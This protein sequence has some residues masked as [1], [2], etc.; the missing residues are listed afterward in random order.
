MH[1][2]TP[3]ESLLKKEL[4]KILALQQPK[5]PK[6]AK[7]ILWVD[8]TD[9]E[10]ISGEWEKDQYL[11]NRTNF[12]AIYALIPDIHQKNLNWAFIYQILC[13]LVIFHKRMK[14][15]FYYLVLPSE[16]EPEHTNSPKQIFAFIKH[17]IEPS[18]HVFGIYRFKA[19]FY[20]NSPGNME[21]TFYKNIALDSLNQVK[22]KF[23]GETCNL[24]LS[25][26]P[27]VC[28]DFNKAFKESLDQRAISFSG[29]LPLTSNVTTR[30]DFISTFGY[31]NDS[32]LEI[33][34]EIIENALDIS[35]SSCQPLFTSPDTPL[36][37]IYN[38]IDAFHNFLPKYFPHRIEF[39]CNL[40]LPTPEQELPTGL[41]CSISSG[42]IN[43]DSLHNEENRLTSLNRI[44]QIFESIG[45]Q[46]GLL[47]SQLNRR[48]N[49]QNSTRI[50]IDRGAVK[51]RVKLESEE[52]LQ[53]ITSL[54]D[55]EY[56]L[57]SDDQYILFREPELF[58][59]SYINFKEFLFNRFLFP[60]TM[61][62]WRTR[63][64]IFVIPIW[65]PSPIFKRT[66][67]LPI[68]C[69]LMIQG[70]RL[71]NLYR[72]IYFSLA[73]FREQFKE[74]G[75][76]VFEIKKRR[77]C[78]DEQFKN[79][80]EEL[81]FIP[82][83]QDRICNYDSLN[84]LYFIENPLPEKA[85]LIEE[86]LRKSE[87]VK[88]I[89]QWILNVFSLVKASFNTPQP[90]ANN[91]FEKYWVPAYYNYH[92]AWKV[93][94][95]MLCSLKDSRLFHFDEVILSIPEG[96]CVYK[97]CEYIDNPNVEDEWFQ[98]KKRALEDCSVPFR[99]DVIQLPIIYSRFREMPS[100][101]LIKWG[102]ENRMIIRERDGKLALCCAAYSF[103][104]PE[105]ISFFFQR[106]EPLSIS[107][108]RERLNKHVHHKI[109][110]YLNWLININYFQDERFESLRNNINSIIL[111]KTKVYESY[112][113]FF[114][115]FNQISAEKQLIN[116]PYFGTF[117]NKESSFFLEN[118]LDL[119]LM[120][121]FKPENSQYCTPRY[122]TYC[123]FNMFLKNEE[124][125][126]NAILKAFESMLILNNNFNKLSHK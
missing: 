16:E 8:L 72:Y 7:K 109:I 35:Q 3:P 108:F 53:L 24:L 69:D 85:T 99:H 83:H 12:D 121:F 41:F 33:I 124:I 18:L 60:I 22:A 112:I 70:F 45:S 56:R 17:S 64:F 27:L 61:P 107:I 106:N 19:L 52:L 15:P 47:R 78:I 103:L 58:K 68:L 117:I 98:W 114:D 21:A 40:K 126:R 13:Y 65:F 105:E 89:N 39:N 118:T 120:N 94:S 63:K 10:K 91:S 11:L 49:R 30:R 76:K 23:A 44:T 25:R 102:V 74:I 115:I 71:L 97:Y 93:A 87:T 92:E 32:S 119:A 37:D 46:I 79:I 110:V 54:V 5:L 104:H 38:E 2:I 26:F 86:N 6:I 9:G 95:Q 113:T 125:L 77:Q 31:L 43:T 75:V 14:I 51:R 123:Y 1:Y 50:D 84:E 48:M 34:K 55:N 90:F 88:I 101:N 100:D 122:F 73:N 28:G 111:M 67:I 116:H 80:M 66:G 57:L 36:A 81:N 42:S 62:S 82:H 20:D 29:S 4:E 59:N 96:I